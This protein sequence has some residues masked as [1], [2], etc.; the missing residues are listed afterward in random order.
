MNK[1]FFIN[2]GA[3]RVLCSIPALER[4]AETHDDFVIVSESWDE[5]YLNNPVLRDK[6][7]SVG[8]KGL[9][10]DHLKDKEIVSPEPYRINQYFNQEC[11]LIQAFDIEINQ[12]DFEAVKRKDR[13]KRE[14]VEKSASYKNLLHFFPKF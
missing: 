4:Y 2:G 9:F 6:T 11:N 3:G 5:L 14:L 8:H 7:Y 12:L 1:A 10:E 13:K